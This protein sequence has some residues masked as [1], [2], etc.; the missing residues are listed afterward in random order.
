M[1]D[2]FALSSAG[3]GSPAEHAA[4]ITPNDA[5]DLP[6]VARAIYIGGAGNVKADVVGGETVTF[7][8]LAAGSVLSMRIK[9][10]HAIGTTA[11]NL[12]ALW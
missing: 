7:T 5:A 6:T 3:L 8:G 1:A 11:T 12:V 2:P 10:V 9:R 4:A